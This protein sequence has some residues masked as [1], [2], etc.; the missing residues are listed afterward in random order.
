[1]TTNLKSVLFSFLIATA[2]GIAALIIFFIFIEGW[3]ISGT[4]LSMLATFGGCGFIM[5]KTR[6]QSKF[7][8]G[9]FISLPILIAFSNFQA[10]SELL[11]SPSSINGRNFYVLLPFLAILFSYLGI[12]LGYKFR[13]KSKVTAYKS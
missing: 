9:I 12:Y 1:M 5:G 3:G 6:P 13:K 10:A 11:A 2:L 4:L 7:Y 8:A